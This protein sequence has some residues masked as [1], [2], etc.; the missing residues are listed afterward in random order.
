MVVAVIVVGSVK[1]ALDEV[2]DMVLMGYRLMPA[3][4]AMRMRWVAVDRG[5]VAPR[6]SLVNRDD[7]FIHV[8]F[9]RVV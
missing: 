3:S 7:V 1:P 4:S 2:V 5:C 6:V 9:V 8:T